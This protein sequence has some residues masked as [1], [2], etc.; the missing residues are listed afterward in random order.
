MSAKQ[1]PELLIRANKRPVTPSAVNATMRRLG[2]NVEWSAEAVEQ[3]K[4]A[5]AAA[6]EYVRQ[7]P[8][9]AE[10]L[11]R[12]PESVLQALVTE[13]LLRTPVD[14]LL[15]A[16]AATRRTAAAPEMTLAIRVADT[17]QAADG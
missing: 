10:E 2:L 14:A 11:V 13:G 17:S 16:L 6:R 12:D 5:A 3:L 4:A 9:K 1:T 15:A 8:E 7:H